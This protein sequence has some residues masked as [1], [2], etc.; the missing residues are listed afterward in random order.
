MIYWYIKHVDEGPLEVDKGGWSSVKDNGSV[1]ECLANET[2]FYTKEA[3]IDNLKMLRKS[4]SKWWCEKFKLIKV[5]RKD[6]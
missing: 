5:T 2:H 1:N 3:A 6:N 4:H